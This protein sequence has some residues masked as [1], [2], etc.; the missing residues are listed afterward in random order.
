MYSKAWSGR[1]V[2][3]TGQCHVREGSNSDTAWEIG[4]KTVP[5]SFWICS[6]DRTSVKAGS[7]GFMVQTT[8]LAEQ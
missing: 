7:R 8:D 4:V 5:F 3:G 2:A 6:I 1:A